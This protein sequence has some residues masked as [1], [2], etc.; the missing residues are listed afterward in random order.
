MM[1]N[2]LIA[3]LMLTSC[4]TSNVPHNFKMSDGSRG[5]RECESQDNGYAIVTQKQF[6]LCNQHML[7][8]KFTRGTYYD[9]NKT[10][11][12]FKVRQPVWGR[13]DRFT[14]KAYLGRLYCK[15]LNGL[16]ELTSEFV[17]R[18]ETSLT[19]SK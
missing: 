9:D 11:C 15:D 19:Q 18:L 3:L 1:E 8:P 6:D 13:N 17:F 16:Y 4:D 5:H 7:N 12:K 10:G 14:N 2:K